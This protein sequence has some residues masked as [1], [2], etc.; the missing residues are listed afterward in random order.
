VLWPGRRESGH[1]LPIYLG[2]VSLV[3]KWERDDGADIPKYSLQP[4]D[5]H[6]FRGMALMD[7]TKSTRRLND[8]PSCWR[9]RGYYNCGDCWQS[10]PMH[11]RCGNPFPVLRVDLFEGRTDSTLLGHSASFGETFSP[12]AVGSGIHK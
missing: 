8:L 4:V 3:D 10:E 1:I 11:I 7:L 6:R 2:L 12:A 9:E 5:W